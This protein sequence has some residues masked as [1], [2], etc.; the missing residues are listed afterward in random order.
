MA[1]YSVPDVKTRIQHIQCEIPLIIDNK[2][3][4]SNLQLVTFR[5]STSVYGIQFQNPISYVVCTHFQQY[6]Q[7]FRD[8]KAG[9]FQKHN[10]THLRI[11][12]GI[13]SGSTLEHI[14]C[15]LHGIFSLIRS[16]VIFSSLKAT[17]CLITIIKSCVGN[18]RAESGN[19]HRQNDIICEFLAFAL[20]SG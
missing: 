18:M 4:S 7:Q 1:S 12:Y 6:I 16:M 11:I 17:A 5:T 15:Q 19:F 3:S 2:F 9:P 14:S 8:W 20:F 13:I 10:L